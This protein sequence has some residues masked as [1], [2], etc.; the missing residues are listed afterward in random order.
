[1]QTG[2]YLPGEGILHRLHPLTKVSGCAALFV[3][4]GLPWQRL[5]LP[6][7]WAGGILLALALA[8]LADGQQ[9]LRTWARRLVLIASPFLISMFLI[10]GFLWPNTTTTLWEWGRLHLSA[11]GLIFSAV[12]ATRLVLVVAGSLLLFLTTH[13]ADFVLG[14]EQI[15][16]S[17]E[18]AYLLLAVLS[19]LPRMYDR[20]QTITA[21]QQARGLRTSGS[22]SQRARA[23]LP[24][25]VPLVISA[26]QDVEERAM[27]LE[28]RAFRAPTPKTT[29]R[30]LHDTHAQRLIRWGMLGMAVASV[31]FTRWYFG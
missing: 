3:L 24:L 10:N 28:A 14:L 18:L 16:L 27:A 17:H 2:L 30:T 13:P 1:M 12:V 20:A 21:A 6:W 8:A 29:I 15:G 31:V 4:T 22:L 26:L 7:L 9:T 23:L 11:E 5:P 25:L 19:L